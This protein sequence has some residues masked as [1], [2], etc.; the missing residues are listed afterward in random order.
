MQSIISGN[1]AIVVTVQH[2]ILALICAACVVLLSISIDSVIKSLDDIL[3]PCQHGTSYSNGRCNCIGTPFHGTFCGECDC[4]NGFCTEGGTTPRITSDYGCRCPHA[5]KFFGYLCDVCFAQNKTDCTGDCD[6]GYRGDRCD[7]KC[8]PDVSYVETL[9]DMTTPDQYACHALRTSGGSCNPCSG[10]G[11]CEDGYCVC[12]DNWFDD[13]PSQCSKTCPISPGGEVCSGNGVCRLYGETAA[14]VCARGWRGDDCSVECPGMAATGKPCTGNGACILDYTNNVPSATCE[15]S[16]KFIG[17]ACD[18][19][20]PG[21]GEICT[22][23]GTCEAQGGNATCTCE[24]DILEW[25]GPGCNCTDLITCNGKGRCESGSCVCDGNRA[26]KNCMHC[27]ENYYGSSCQF[28]CDPNSPTNETHH[29]CNGRG[30]CI[31]IDPGQASE[32]IGCACISD[33]VRKRI[34]RNIESFYSTFDADIDCADCAGGYFPKTS[35]FEDYDTSPLGLYVPCQIQCAASTCNDLGECNDRYGQ[36]GESLC[37][38]DSSG[39]KH[40]NGTS[41]C[42]KCEDNW[43]PN[44]VKETGGCSNF[45]ISDVALIGGTFPAVCDTGEIDCVDC[46][47]RGSCNENGK[48]VCDEGFTGNSCS[49]QCTSIISG[50]ICGGHG[51]CDSNKLQRLF[52]HEFEFHANSGA[53][54]TCSCDPQDVFTEE[55][56]AEAAENNRSISVATKSYFGETCDYHCAKPPWAGADECNGMGNCTVYNIMD[57]NDNTFPCVQDSD[58]RVTAIQQITSVDSRWSEIN[59]PFCDKSTQACAG[60]AYTIDDCYDIV[61]LQRPEK[62]RGKECVES[63][64][65][66]HALIM[67]DWHQWCQNKGTAPLDA[68]QDCGDLSHMCPSRNINNMCTVYAQAASTGDVSAHMDYCYENDKKKYPFHI[69]ETHRLD[70]ASVEYHRKIHH[71]MERYAKEHPQVNIDITQYCGT[72]MRKFETNITSIARNKRYTCG[73]AIV[74]NENDCLYN[75]NDL[76]ELWMP[77]SVNCPGKDPTQYI[78]YDDA[79]RSRGESCFITEDEPR[80]VVSNPGVVPFGGLCYKDSD[81]A[82]ASCL[83]NTCCGDFNTE[84]CNSCNNIGQCTGCMNGATW[85][86]TMCHKMSLQ[87]HRR[88]SF[89][90]VPQDNTCTISKMLCGWDGGSVESGS[91]SPTLTDTFISPPDAQRE[92]IDLIDLTCEAA[93]VHFPVCKLPNTACDVNACKDGDTC[94]PSGSDGICATTGVLDC[95]CKYGMSCV[96]LTFSTYK[97]V[98]DFTADISCPSAYSKLNWFE[99]CKNND[100]VLKEMQFGSNALQKNDPIN[101]QTSIPSETRFIRYWVQP[102]TQFSTSKYLEIAHNN[103]TIATVYLH[104]GQ[105]QLNEVSTLESCPVTSPDCLSAWAY[106][107]NEWHELEIAMDFVNKQVTLTK[108]G[109]FITKPFPCAASGCIPYYASELAINGATIT[110]YDN[111]VMEREIPNPSIYETCQSYPFCDVDVNYRQ[112][113][114]NMLR[115]LQYPLVLEPKYDIVSTCSNFFDFQSFASYERL[116]HMERDAIKKLDW[117]TYCLYTD[118]IRGEYDCGNHGYEYYEEYEQCRDILEP[119]PTQQCMLTAV[120]ANWDQVCEDISL[121]DIPT[122]IRTA[123]PAKCYNKLK[124]YSECN[125]RSDLFVDNLHVKNSACPDKWIDFC[126]AAAVGRQDGKCSAVGCNCDTESYEGVSGG[127][128]ELHCLVASDGTA[129]GEASGVGRCDYTDKEKAILSTGTKDEEG[130]LVAYASNKFQI[131]GE[132]N[133]FLSEGKENCDQECLKCNETVIDGQQIGIC[134]GARGVCDCLPP[135]TVMN[136]I[137]TT[138]WRGTTVQR[139]ER[140]YGLPPEFNAIE[141]FRIRAMQGKEVFVKEYL[142]KDGA[143]AYTSGDWKTIYHDF[144]DEPSRYECIPGTACTHHDFMLLGN[145]ADSSTRYN[146]DCNSECLG[147]DPST[148]IPCSGHGACRV[149]GVCACDPAAIV[150]GVNEVSGAS[151]EI[152]FANGE[153]YENSEVEVSKYDRTGWRGNDCSKMCPGYDPVTKSMLKV[154]SGHGICDDAA[155]CQ[156]EV[157]YI[158]D[159]CQFLC[160]GFD[161]SDINVCS[162]HGT[163]TVNLIEIVASNYTVAFDG[164]CG[165]TSPSNPDDSYAAVP[166]EHCVTTC[167]QILSIGFGVKEAT[168]ETN[169][170]S[171]TQAECATY[172]HP[173]HESSNMVVVSEAGTIPGCYVEDGQTYFNTGS[174]KWIEVSP[175]KLSSN[176]YENLATYLPG[177]I[178]S[179]LFVTV[180]SDT[181]DM[182][183]SIED[184]RA[185]AVAEGYTWYGLYENS[186]NPNGCFLQFSTVYYN[187]NGGS[188]SLNSNSLCVQKAAIPTNIYNTPIARHVDSPRLSEYYPAGLATTWVRP[189]QYQDGGVE[190]V[191]SVDEDNGNAVVSTPK[192]SE[193]DIE[194]VTS[195]VPDLSIGQVECEAYAVAK[196]YTWYGEYTYSGNPNGCFLQS[197]TVYYNT[198]GGSCTNVHGSSCIRKATIIV[199]SGAPDLSMSQAECQAY[200]ASKSL[201]YYGGDYGANIPSGCWVHGDNVRYSTY[202]SST[203]CGTEH[204]DAGGAVSCLQKAQP[205]KPLVCTHCGTG[206]CKYCDSANNQLVTIQ[207]IQRTTCNNLRSDG[208]HY[209]TTCLDAFYTVLGGWNGDENPITSAQCQIY[210]SQIGKTFSSTSSSVSWAYPSKCYVNLDNGNVYWNSVI[211]TYHQYNQQCGPNKLSQRYNPGYQQLFVSSE[212]IRPNDGFIEHNDVYEIDSCPQPVGGY[213]YPNDGPYCP[214][215]DYGSTFTG[216]ANR[217][218]VHIPAATFNL[219]A[220]DAALKLFNAALT[221]FMAD[222]LVTNDVMSLSQADCQAAQVALFPAKPMIVPATAHNDP[223]YGCYRELDQYYYNTIGTGQCGDFICSQYLPCNDDQVCLQQDPH[224]NTNNREFTG[225]IRAVDGKCICTDRNCSAGEIVDEGAFTTYEP[226]GDGSSLSIQDCSYT[227]SDWTD[228]DGERQTRETSVTIQ[229]TFGGIECPVSPEY[230]SCAFQKVDCS[231][232]WEPWGEC[233]GTYQRRNLTIIDQPLHGGLECPISPGVRVCCSDCSK[234]QAVAE[235]EKVVINAPDTARAMSIEE[236][237]AYATLIGQ[238]DAYTIVQVTSAAPDMSVS[239]AE[240]EAYGESIGEWQR[241]DSWDDIVSGCF[242]LV[243]G[244]TYYNTYV[245]SITCGTNGY[246]CLQK[247][248]RDFQIYNGNAPPGCVHGTDRVEWNAAV[249]TQEVTTGAPDLSMSQAECEAYALSNGHTWKGISTDYALSTRWQCGDGYRTCYGYLR[250]YAWGNCIGECLQRNTPKGCNYMPTSNWMWFT[251][252]DTTAECG[253]SAEGSSGQGQSYKAN[254]IQKA[255]TVVEVTAEAPDLSMSEAECQA[256]AVDN[257]VTWYGHTNGYFSLGYPRGCVLFFSAVRYNRDLTTGTCS[258]LPTDLKCLQKVPYV[259]SCGGDNYACVYKN[260]L[261][262]EDQSGKCRC[263]SGTLSNGRCVETSRRR[264]RSTHALTSSTCS[265]CEG[266]CIGGKCCNALYTD[267]NNC[268]KCN[269]DNDV[270]EYELFEGKFNAWKNAAEE[271][272]AAAIA[273]CSAEAGCSGITKERGK[274]TW[275]LFKLDG[276]EESTDRISYKK[277]YLPEQYCSECMP[278]STWS[279]TRQRCMASSCP[280]GQVWVNN[281]GCITLRGEVDTSM[282]VPIQRGLASAFCSNGFYRD[283]NTNECTPASFHPIIPITFAVEKGTVDEVDITVGCEVWKSNLVKCPRCDCFSDSLYGKWDS[284]ECETCK[285]GS[286]K[287]QCRVDCPGFDGISDHTMCNNWGSCSYGSELNSNGERIFQDATCTCGNPPGSLN[288]KKTEMQLYNSFHRPFFTVTE[289]S[290]K[291]AC[292]DMSLIRTELQDVCYHFDESQSDCSLC[293]EGFSGDNCRHKCQKCLAGGRCDHTPSNSQSAACTC[294]ALFGVSGVLWR[295]NCCPVGF[296]VTDLS[297]FEKLPQYIGGSFAIDSISIGAKYNPAVYENTPVEIAQRNA[298][299]W[300]KPCPGVDSSIDGS[301]MKPSAQYEVCGG[302]GRGECVVDTPHSNKCKC[303]AGNGGDVTDPTQDWVGES[304]RC[305]HSDEIAFVNLQ[306]DYGCSGKGICLDKVVTL[307]VN[308]V[309]TTFAC[310]ANPGYYFDGGIVTIA[311]VGTHAPVG[312]ILYTEFHMT[313]DCTF[314]KDSVSCVQCNAGYY[315]NE[316]GSIVCKA[317]SA[318]QFSNSPGRKTGCEPCA[319]GKISA[320][321]GQAICSGCNNGEYQPATGQSSCNVCTTGQTTG[322]SGSF[323]SCSSCPAGKRGVPPGQCETCPVGQYTGSAGQA[324]CSLC[325]VGHYC[326]GNGF[327]TPCHES[328]YQNQVGQSSCK[329]CNNA[330]YQFGTTNGNSPSAGGT[331]CGVCPGG[332]TINKKPGPSVNGVT[333]TDCTPGK[334]KNTPFGTGCF[335]CPANQMTDQYGQSSCKYCPS[336]YI[337]RGYYCTETCHRWTGEWCTNLYTCR[338]KRSYGSGKC[339]PDQARTTK[340][341]YTFTCWYGGNCY[342]YLLYYYA[343][344]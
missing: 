103:E 39:G 10:H 137:N 304:C 237:D 164:R 259:P 325:P 221:T 204:P 145:L 161:D 243:N 185:Y 47:G 289:Q 181:P 319:V 198:N 54:S 281:A 257:G 120:N 309:A 216:D 187:T 125:A 65:C 9:G 142:K 121:R 261:P 21:D 341:T 130:N 163:C 144:R 101:L 38:C 323:T 7:R 129:C 306:T 82:G 51:V 288:E 190:V 97:C 214:T 113:C 27:K 263:L 155:R 210:A 217:Y 252:E 73:S 106:T 80:N 330:N 231:G 49:M 272:Y 158:G 316:E 303:A 153:T 91:G 195:G 3:V 251:A 127:S 140:A 265:N 247:S 33:E 93:T 193:G 329:Q 53:T 317:C 81:C 203:P 102:T 171:L 178:Y 297:A 264:L 60:D 213:N 34:G 301:W 150:V 143:S 132:C 84:N 236:C 249:Y 62:T 42:T 124:T 266:K 287:K 141:E 277:K 230:R 168:S 12:D 128:C 258:H 70:G 172:V 111:I 24:S 290:T 248:P 256:Y 123:C 95:S 44:N 320:N 169:D 4:A 148:D 225:A 200:A 207:N 226:I 184:C 188:C 332:R 229:P 152:T 156:C 310:Q 43:F 208:Q 267:I 170:G 189:A 57:P 260:N 16:G 232:I 92:G 86:G 312:A 157:G 50:E 11:T 77:F 235:Y 222:K 22:G 1:M 202:A 280:S 227:W 166:V 154:C 96:P 180:D 79:V 134:D 69:D 112:K 206:T 328:A 28:F 336:S 175:I 2:G 107:P 138:T 63:E 211:S 94:T 294:K 291:V 282:Q 98:S 146:Y 36:P 177:V 278:G 59:G 233:D 201:S 228:C 173:V 23:H 165:Y 339:D 162:G 254:C 194:E 285:K 197:S 118:S 160:P 18:A 31:V 283:M 298:D 25:T 307:S 240:C 87:S 284:F 135:Y 218:P 242:S 333:C 176:T 182:S 338:C 292:T 67:F 126:F 32:S 55:A 334:Y 133:C 321:D 45:C 215:T 149:T 340:R 299:Y 305:R 13:E 223:P 331:I 344:C 311:P 151:V 99:Y 46:N 90:S 250:Q 167:Q 205:F 296:R 269:A 74:S 293:E 131:D 64:T 308:G 104:Q 192:I 262:I 5:S 314:V 335:N 6:A 274:E 110:Y 85:N 17:A 302:L 276:F 342:D 279:T 20:C 72:H 318:G 115:T 273:E 191:Y 234:C 29:G 300:C 109:A 105:V 159:T 196:E 270:Y 114:S 108:G 14:C 295:Y 219:P 26:G 224:G 116:S 324:S 122:E 41:Y 66:R 61:R 40:V 315:Q 220:Y 255:T 245:N 37:T 8:F 89:L 147:I 88:R 253:V 136:E 30:T 56:L 139:L 83:S 275:S 183:M 209:G 100:P 78:L 212:C 239:E 76:G 343:N 71:E 238:V 327:K 244:W 286:G 19:E 75:T 174:T 313:Q 48:C 271:G 199:T 52:E 35:V 268:L 58:C 68:L 186:G 322:S 241:T 337:A 179:G 246:K 326:T 15:C 117:D 119:F